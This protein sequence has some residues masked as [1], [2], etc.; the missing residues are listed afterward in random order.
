MGW[1]WAS[2]TPAVKQPEIPT[3]SPSD[4]TPVSNLSSTSQYE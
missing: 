3:P 1:F 2:A 4:A